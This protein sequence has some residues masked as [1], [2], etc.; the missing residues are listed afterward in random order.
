MSLFP[1]DFLHSR[2]RMPGNQNHDLSVNKRFSITTERSIELTAVGLNF[3]N[4]A[5][6]TD[7]DTMIGPPSAPNV[8]AGRIIGSRGGR[9]IQLGFRYSF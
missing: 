9:V 6:W 2:L 3:V 7:P 4:L 1:L 8:N 5:N